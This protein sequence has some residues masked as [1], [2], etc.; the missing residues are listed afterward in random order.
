MINSNCSAFNSFQ[1]GPTGANEPFRRN[2]EA[3]E[4]GFWEDQYMDLSSFEQVGLNEP[5]FSEGLAATLPDLPLLNQDRTSGNT[6]SISQIVTQNTS[7][8]NANVPGDSSSIIQT[9]LPSYQESSITPGAFETEGLI[10]AGT[11]IK[12]V[13]PGHHGG[14]E[15]VLFMHYLDQVFYVQFPF[16]DFSAGLRNRGWL[17]T[18]LTEDQPIYHATLAL[19][20]CH[21]RIAHSTSNNIGC[22]PHR[23]NER[24]KHY[25]FALRHLQENLRLV[26]TWDS[27]AGLIS[28]IQTL[29]CIL[30]LLF[31]EVRLKVPLMYEYNPYL[32]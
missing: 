18:L 32:I 13:I 2:H 3:Y 17:Y 19:S 30:Q 28:N 16:Y 14:E 27:A 26:H 8:I 22:D 11:T 21:Q 7:H 24:T 29:G 15:A 23:E 1:D 25:V 9:C 31:I 5:L 10:H 6:T 12:R 4:P 20:Q